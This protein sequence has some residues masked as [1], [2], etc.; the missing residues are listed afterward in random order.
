[1]EV[2]E[3]ATAGPSGRPQYGSYIIDEQG[4]LV[5]PIPQMSMERSAETRSLAIRDDHG[6]IRAG[7]PRSP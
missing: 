4:L 1:M 3:F 6:R 2:A 7:R 5:G